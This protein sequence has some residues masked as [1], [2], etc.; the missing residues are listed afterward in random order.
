MRRLLLLL[1]APDNPQRVTALMKQLAKNKETQQC[2]VYQ[3][4]LGS[5]P[6]ALR[7][8]RAGSRERSHGGGAEDHSL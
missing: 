5:L 2:W 7:D 1:Q 4:R 8:L 3:G 6:L